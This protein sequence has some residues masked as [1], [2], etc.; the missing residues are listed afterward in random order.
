MAQHLKLRAGD[1]EDLGIISACMQ[2][3]LISF[4]DLSFFAG[5]RRFVLVAQRFKWENCPEFMR[6]DL[7]GMMPCEN[8]E[9]VS[10]VLVFD[11][12]TGVRLLDLT[13]PEDTKILELL[14]IAMEPGEEGGDGPS[15]ILFF[16]GGGAIRLEVRRILCHLE[17]LGE[18]W[19]TIRRPS[20]P[21]DEGA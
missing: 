3:A 13:P 1:E 5:E 15:V 7:I 11:D 16:A 10:S 14:A 20:H 12:V 18:S 19:P 17:D 8:Y 4:N 21:V 9:R 2:D 6:P